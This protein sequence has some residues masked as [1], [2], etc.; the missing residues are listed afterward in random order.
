MMKL[1]VAMQFRVLSVFT[2]LLMASS[3]LVEAHSCACRTPDSLCCLSPETGSSC[4]VSPTIQD[5]AAWGSHA[6]ECCAQSLPEQKRSDPFTIQRQTTPGG[7]DEP[8]SPAVALSSLALF[9]R[10]TFSVLF[11]AVHL[12]RIPGHLSSTVLRL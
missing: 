5:G 10:R 9:P 6:C 7:S 8:R 4:C 3:I 2:T 1:R 12:P 11:A